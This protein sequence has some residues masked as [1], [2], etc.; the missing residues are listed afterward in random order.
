MLNISEQFTAKILYPNKVM[1]IGC[2]QD[3]KV[4]FQPNG[5]GASWNI[6]GKVL[7]AKVIQLENQ[8]IYIAYIIVKQHVMCG[9]GLSNKLIP[10]FNSIQNPIES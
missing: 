3:S 6:N 4:F 1:R 5:I 10:L 9:V 7:N 8:E 2:K